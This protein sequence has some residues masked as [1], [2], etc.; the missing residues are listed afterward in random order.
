V[1]SDEFNG[2]AAFVK[3]AETCSFSR[4]A[5]ELGVSSPSI[6]E[7]IKAL[8]TRLGVRLL[9]RTTRSVGLTEAGASYFQRVRAAMEEIRS[10]RA[11]LT[12]MRERPMGTLRLSAP[13]IA[14]PLLIEPLMAPFLQS[15]PDVKLDVVFDDGLV[16]LAGEG[17][18]AGVRIGEL[19]EKDMVAVRVGG[20][21]RMAVLASPDYL[22]SQPAP[23][24]PDQLGPHRCIAYRFASTRALAQWEFIEN[25]R[26]INLQP[27][28]SLSVNTMSL[29]IR[30]AEQGLGLGYVPERLA[31]DQL[32]RGTL[33][34]V[35][36]RFCPSYE[37]L[38][39]YY[40][41]HRLTPPKLKVFVE[42]ARKQFRQGAS[43]HHR[44]R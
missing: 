32:Q 35:L 43:G 39:I 12:E 37:P 42:L 34:K 5:A 27:D 40:P 26:E 30:A 7:A 13:W 28:A 8:E 25:G 17:F 3:V 4:A 14:G 36:E 23:K 33:V 9:N 22:A 10:A 21:V 18:D 44:K 16:D 6:S 41:T 2:L 11:A 20:P 31:A 38:H 24:R 15:Y 29:I 1:R 19:V